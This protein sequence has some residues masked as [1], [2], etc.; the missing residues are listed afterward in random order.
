MVAAPEALVLTAPTPAL[1]YL[2][3]GL[4][5]ASRKAGVPNVSVNAIP[6]T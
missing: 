4:E 1:V 5:K 6:R 3:I 2:G